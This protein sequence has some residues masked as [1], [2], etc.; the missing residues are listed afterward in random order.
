MIVLLIMGSLNKFRQLVLIVEWKGHVLITLSQFLCDY[1]RGVNWWMYLL[2][3]YTHHSELQ[4]ITALSLISTFYKSPQHPLS[5]F[6]PAVS[7]SAI[8]WQRLLT[9]DIL[10]LHALRC[11]CH[12][13]PCRTHLSPELRRRLFLASFAELN[14]QLTTPRLAAISHQPHT[15]LFTARHSTEHW[16]VSIPLSRP[17]FLVI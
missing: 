5:L 7:S 12:S 8:P 15:L 16:T 11:S 14:S 9:V 17:G 2:T 3:D 1:R 10:Q 6:Q 13:R 4:V